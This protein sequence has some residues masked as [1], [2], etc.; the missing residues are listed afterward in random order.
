MTKIPIRGDSTSICTA[1]VQ[2]AMVQKFMDTQD[3]VAVRVSVNFPTRLIRG[4]QYRYV[5]EDGS[6]GIYHPGRDGAL[7]G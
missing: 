3:D 5:G 4:T 7:G 2:I 1:I 6:L